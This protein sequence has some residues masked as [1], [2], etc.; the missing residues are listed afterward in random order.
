MIIYRG[1][2][3]WGAGKGSNLTPPEID[4]NFW[5]LVQRLTALE[6]DP[7]SPDE[8]DNITQ[9]GDTIT[10]HMQSGATFGPFTLPRPVFRPTVGVDITVSTYTPT[11]ANTGYYH[12][13]THAAGCAVTIPP[14]S[15]APFLVDAEMHW[16]QGAANAI[17]FTAGAGVTLRGIDGYLLQSAAQGAVITAKC[18]GDD[19][20]DLFGMFAEDT[21]TGTAG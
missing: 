7:P 14:N 21:T 12:N 20:W 11:T 17:S 15:A 8:I 9:N 5:E 4:G 1:T 19:I 10:V 3:A 13:C 6:S 18:R 16:R 2:G